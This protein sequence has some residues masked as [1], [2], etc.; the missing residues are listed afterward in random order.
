M[1]LR[2]IFLA[3]GI[4]A[5]TLPPIWWWLEM[6]ATYS[7]KVNYICG[8]PALAI[9]LLAALGASLLSFL[10]LVFA[11]LSYRRAPKPRSKL[12]LAEMIVVALPFIVC[13]PY[14]T[15]LLLDF[16]V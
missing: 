8:L 4:A 14:V 9:F 3:L 1:K 13:A 10:G 6:D 16:D 2:T 11:T 15:A 5:Y 7:G 12:R